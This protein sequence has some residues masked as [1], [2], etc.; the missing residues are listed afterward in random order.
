MAR[1]ISSL[2]ASTAS[3]CR[4][5]V[6]EDGTYTDA[7]AGLRRR[8]RLQG[9]P[10]RRSPTALY[11]RIAH[12]NLLA[13]GTLVHSYP[14]SWRSKAPLIFRATRSG[15]SRWRGRTSCATRRWPRSTPP[16][17]CRPRAATGSRSMIETRPDWC[18]VAPARLGR[19]DR[20]VRRQGDRRG[21]ARPRGGRA[22]RRRVRGRR[23][24]T[25]GGPATRRSS[26]ATA[27]PPPTTRRST[28]SSTSGSKRLHPRHRAGA[29]ARAAMAGLALS[30]G[31]GPASRLV[32]LLAAGELR[33]ARPGA[34]RRGPD[35]RLRG[36]RRGPQDVQVAGQRRSR[37]ST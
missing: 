27:T 20:R 18:V 34:L 4:D 10:S 17:G 8:A 15:S 31:L 33:H 32:P 13:R 7:G 23:L 24:R 22:D 16:A 9:R 1:T 26:W 21:A 30:R 11:L 14:H 36:R 2:A 28:T 25:R 37:R 29:A 35:P 3:R 12:G 6:A 5:T 19:A